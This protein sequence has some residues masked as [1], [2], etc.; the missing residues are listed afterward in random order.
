MPRAET[1]L[2]GWARPVTGIGASV[3]TPETF[4]ILEKSAFENSGDPFWNDA[5]GDDCYYSSASFLSALFERRADF[6]QI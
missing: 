6:G 2:S 4:D 1:A 3:E 5:S